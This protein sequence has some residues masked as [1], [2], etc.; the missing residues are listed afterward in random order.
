MGM[1]ASIQF[2]GAARGVTGS[3]YLLE[4]G[5]RRVLV[6]CGLYQERQLQSRN[7]DPFPVPPKSIDA[8]VITHAHLDHC[9]LLPRLVRDGFSGPVISTPATAEIAR[10]QML[11]TA[12]IQDE[13]AAFKARRHE[14]EGRKKD[15]PPAALYTP[16]DAELA[17][18]R[19]T[20]VRCG[21]THA[22][23]DDLSVT[24]HD[25]GHILGSA[26]VESRFGSGAGARRV[27]F[28]GDL[29]RWNSPIL[30]DPTL[31]EQADYVL[32]ESTY[33]DRLHD[34]TDQSAEKLAGI[35]D[36]TCKAGGNIV[37]PS[38]A[39]ERTQDILY[40][41]NLMLL[42]NSIPHVLVFIDSPMAVSVTRVFMRHMY[43]FDEAMTKLVRE[44]R[45]PFEFPGLVMV[46]SVDQSKSINRV[47]GSAIVIAGS[48]MCTGG[49]IKHH[50]VT[51]ITRPESSVVFVGYQAVGT[52]GRFISDGAKEV[53]ILGQTYGVKARIEQLS[54]FSAHADRDELL[55]WLSGFKTAPRRVF[56][57][58]GEP[59]TAQ[60]FASFV[61][62]RRQFETTVP[63]FGDRVALA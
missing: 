11:D 31:I 36:R 2:L 18:Q 19:F 52:L 39:V 24:L 10:I 49:R 37:I 23:S 21:Q 3:R 25:A 50:L 29:G 26:M 38:F 47:K 48:G 54:G 12:R 28:S 1:S 45:S 51:N 33:G 62:E 46:E 17:A 14:R 60:A 42:A 5:G 6:D 13:D 63:S 43:L 40:H 22:I 56:V 27:V 8:V 7:W 15:P 16:R 9:G 41:L 30:R 44:N 58:H 32:V 57:T 20:P 35:I 4:A 34:R 53:R 55:R 61:R 59:D